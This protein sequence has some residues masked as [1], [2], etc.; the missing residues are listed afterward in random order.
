MS[1]NYWV[2]I[3]L[4][5]LI[6]SV[7]VRH[8][9]KK[10]KLIFLNTSD[11]LEGKVLHQNYSE[12][13]TMPGQAKKSIKKDDILFSEIRPK[14]KRFAYIDFDATDYVVST[15]LMVL[16]KKSMLIDNKF[17]YKLLTSDRMLNY[18]QHIAEGRSGTFP[19][20]TFS[21]LKN[22]EVLLPPMQEQILIAKMLDDLD[23]KIQLNNKINNNLEKIAESIFKQWF[24]DFDFSN[25]NGEPYK[26]SGGEMIESELGEIP[27]G[28]EVFTL[29]KVATISAGG[30]KP[31]VFSK[32]SF[33]EYVVPIYSNGIDNE[34]LYGYT[35]T[36]KIYEESVTVSARGTIGYVCLRQQPYFPIVRLISLIP[37]NNIISSK[38]LYLYLK[39][40]NITGTGT[41]QQQLTVP[42]FKKTKIS[43]PKYNIMKN[44]TE[45]INPIFKEII[46]K[47]LEN[48]K[49]SNLRDTLLPKLMSGEITINSVN[50]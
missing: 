8:D 31:K 38:Y 49:L 17:L 16:R 9:F 20:I 10:E 15:K 45:I 2:S 7:S 35:D 6:E 21:E 43:I 34:G 14:N 12:V 42:D 36:P 24:V 25:Q 23:E 3:K 4:G 48:I 11:V 22:I 44:F 19:Q 47:K 32:I 40:I 18:L 28:W 37:N 29:D 27:K 46:L 13:S 30:D 39:S 1:S 50:K 33:D 5:E 26:S 41:T